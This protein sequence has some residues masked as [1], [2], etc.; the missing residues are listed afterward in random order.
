MTTQSTTIEIVR[1]SV[2]DQDVDAIVNAANTA[3]QGGGGI[4]GVI[5]RAA[6]RG[7]LAELE[8]VAPNG[9]KTGAAVL[10]G[11]HNLKQPYIL[12]TPGPVWKGGGANEA[13]KLAMCY[14]SCLEKAEEKGLKSI[15]FCSISTG[16][17]GYPLPLAA[18]VALKT[19]KE[20]L[21]DHPDTSL[22]RVV[23]AMYQA[24]EFQAFTQAWDAIQGEAAAS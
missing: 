15:A 8:K 13:E 22:D 17:Y 19:V 12:H 20:Y 11:G 10:T 6:G 21:D 14:R 3:M 5:H 9:A 4:D 18:P 7:L 16:I 2:V 24:S 23:F 1:G